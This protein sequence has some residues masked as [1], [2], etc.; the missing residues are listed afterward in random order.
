MRKENV[1]KLI[2]LLLAAVLCLGLAA[3]GNGEGIENT[4]NSQEQTTGTEK[5]SEESKQPTQATE[6][7][8]VD[9][10]PV[11]STDDRISTDTCEFSI[12]YI[13]IT[14]DVL[15]PSPGSW[16]THYEADDGKVYVDVCFAY[17]NTSGKSVGADDIISA[18]LKYADKYEYSDFSII[19]EDNRGNSTYSNI[20]SIAPLCTEYIHFLFVVP[21]EIQNSSESIIIT[22][23]VSGNTYTYTVR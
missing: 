17:K 13:N 8:Q 23:S 16:Y 11:I 15:P 19:E 1:K 14:D 2:A 22:F 6:S 21:E 20:S 5:A 3:C 12:D 4:D 7:P 18:K 10:T 9:T